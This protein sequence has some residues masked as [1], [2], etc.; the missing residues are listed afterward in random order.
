MNAQRRTVVVAGHG[1][2]GHRFVEAIRARDEAGQWQVVVLGEEKLAAY[3]R[4]GLSS[5]V[6]SWEAASLALPGNEYAGDD[7]VD[8]RLGQ[9][10]EAIARA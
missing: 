8:L 4:V 1:M 9:R 10:A 3:D 7:L 2:V 5:Y 6:G